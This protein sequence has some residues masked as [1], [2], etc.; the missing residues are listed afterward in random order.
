MTKEKAIEIIENL[1]QTI[2]RMAPVIKLLHKNE[3]YDTPRVS[4]D[5]LM[6]KK[7]KLIQKY[8]LK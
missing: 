4:R 7:R 2:D 5:I 3:V 6:R 1:T 8:N